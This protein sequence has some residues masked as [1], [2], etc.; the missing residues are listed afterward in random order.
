LLSCDYC[1]NLQLYSRW[2]EYLCTTGVPMLTLLGAN[3]VFAKAGTEAFPRGVKYLV[4]GL[5]DLGNFALENN[6]EYYAEQ[7]D[8]FLYPRLPEV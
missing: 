7:F 8:K 5:V 6:V 3:D 1:T 4:V 2:Q